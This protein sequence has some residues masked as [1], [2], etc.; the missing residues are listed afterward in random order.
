ED[1]LARIGGDEF[2]AVLNSTSLEAANNIV[3]RILAEINQKDFNLAIPLT[4][5][6]GA[7]AKQNSE[8]DINQ[9]FTE[10]DQ[11]MYRYKKR[12]YKTGR[13]F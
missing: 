4:I 6:A 2:A 11:E 3:E 9:V 12:Y 8:Q 10:A 5:S 7:A 13:S 1:I